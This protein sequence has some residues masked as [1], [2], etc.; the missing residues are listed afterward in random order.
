[1]VQHVHTVACPACSSDDVIRFGTNATGK[2]R[3]RCR[4]CRRAFV[5]APQAARGADRL[6]DPA[7]VAQV[8]AAYQER[9]SMRGVARTFKISRNTLAALLKKSERPA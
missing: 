2:Q 8:L 4:A 3:Y 6:K 9:S 1:M 5:E 7:F